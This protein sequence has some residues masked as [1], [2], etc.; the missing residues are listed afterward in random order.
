M[1]PVVRN[2]RQ[3]PA[4]LSAGL[5]PVADNALSPVALP[6]YVAEAKRL[7]QPRLSRIRRPE[8][9]GDHSFKAGVRSSFVGRGAWGG[10]WFSEAGK[11]GQKDWGRDVKDMERLAVRAGGRF[12]G[13]ALFR[14]TLPGGNAAR[15]RA[16]K[17]DRHRNFD[18]W[19]W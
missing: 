9:R 4:K 2:T 7:K 3:K 10:R 6:R 13:G 12:L 17:G 18:R 14:G 1:G 11:L 8:D 15:G 5:F 19:D 16:E